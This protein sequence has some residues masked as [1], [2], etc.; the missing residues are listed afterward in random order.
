[1]KQ[2]INKPALIRAI[3]QLPSYSPPDSLWAEV[4][5]KL[6]RQKEEQPLRQALAAL[7]KYQPGAETWDAIAQHLG[8]GQQETALRTALGGLPAYSPPDSVWE[9]IE[10]QLVPA[11]KRQRLWPKIMQAAAAT[12][13]LLTVLWAAWPTSGDSSLKVAYEHGATALDPS[14]TAPSLSAAEPEGVQA[15]IVAFRK[16]PVAQRHPEYQ[17]TLQEW[18]ELSAAHEEIKSIMAKYG[19]DPKLIRQISEIERERAGLI[20]KMVRE[21]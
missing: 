20:Q 8:Q 15:V 11:A 17:R 19:Q 6:A 16:D 5:Q 3:G 4:E 2:E 9:G 14:L 7:P 10:Q 21:I 18:K 1:M 12:A 13:A